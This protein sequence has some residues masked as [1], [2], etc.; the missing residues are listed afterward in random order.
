MIKTKNILFIFVIAVFSC[1]KEKQP[2]DTFTNFTEDFESYTSYDSTLFATTKWS[3]NQKTFDDNNYTID[4]NI[5]H[6]GNKSLRCYAVASTSKDVSKCSLIKGNMYFTK[7]DI[8][9]YSAWYFVSGTLTNL[10]LVDFEENAPISSS[11]GVRVALFNDGYLSLER[12]KLGLNTI[13]Q[14][15]NT[16]ILFPQNQWVH[17]EV[18]LKLERPKKGY[19]KI[20]QDG[21]LLIDKDG[22]QTLSEDKLYFTQGT[23]GVFHNLEVGITANGKGGNTILFI[24][25]IIAQKIN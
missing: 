21:V 18:E 16:K 10:F 12:G 15:E 8:I 14:D 7:H 11:P 22:I 25:D 17:V 19:V 23:R 2:A 13:Y 3:T 1:T 4:T 20:W 5:V 24:D 9:K 6:S